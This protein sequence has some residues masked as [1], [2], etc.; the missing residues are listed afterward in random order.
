MKAENPALYNVNFLGPKYK[1][2][3]RLGVNVEYN[4][5]PINLFE[6]LGW[7]RV[8]GVSREKHYRRFYTQELETVT[9]IMKRPSDFD[10]YELKKGQVRGASTGLFGGLF[11]KQNKDENG[12][13]ST[14]KSCGKF[15]GLIKVTRT[16]K[17]QHQQEDISKLLGKV[18]DLLCEIHTKTYMKPFPFKRGLFGEISL[19]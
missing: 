6:P 7:D 16:S 15:K 11:K 4:K 19:T 1:Q 17:I 3:D 14:S 18:Y 10:Q 8:P 12:E 9:N 13:I 2:D 5:P